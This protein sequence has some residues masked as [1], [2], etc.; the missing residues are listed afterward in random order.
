[1][2]TTRPTTAPNPAGSAKSPGGKQPAEPTKEQGRRKES[3]RPG[4]TASRSDLCQ[5]TIG[6]CRRCAEY[7]DR[8]CPACVQRRRRAMQLLEQ[9]RTIEQI[10]ASLRLPVPRTKRYIEEEET[11]RDL[12]LY[13]PDGAKARE[14]KERYRGCC[15]H[16]NTQTSG[17]GAGY[18]Q[19]RCHRCAAREAASGTN[20]A[21]KQRYAHGSNA[22]AG[23]RAAP[24]SA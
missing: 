13:D 24:I 23:P 21:S 3:H 9:G 22:T 20:H 10:A 18:P 8:R 15:Q 2:S 11:A 17:A 7:P 12:A 14:V 16:C 1:V 6:G 5:Q 19:K 4:S